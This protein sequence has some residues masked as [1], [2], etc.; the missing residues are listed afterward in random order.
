VGKLEL[1]QL[2]SAPIQLPAF[3]QEMITWCQ[4]TYDP[5]ARAE[6]HLALH[7]PAARTGAGSRDEHHGLALHPRSSGPGAW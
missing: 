2:R 4:H 1:W 3:L 7:L 5:P 6:E